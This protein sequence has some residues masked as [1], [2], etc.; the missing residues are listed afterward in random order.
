MLLIQNLQ[1]VQQLST[2]KRRTSFIVSERNERADHRGTAL[3]LAEITLNT[4][5]RDQDMRWNTVAGRD[6]FEQLPVLFKIYAALLDAPVRDD[7]VQI[8]PEI[9]LELRLVAIELD[10]AYHRSHVS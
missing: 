8:V 5:G 1:C 6:V 4:P 2:K 10:D 3:G 9:E 7:S